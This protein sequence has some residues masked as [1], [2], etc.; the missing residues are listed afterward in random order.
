MA[1]ERDEEATEAQ[2]VVEALLVC[3]AFVSQ[4]RFDA[5]LKVL[6]VA[7]DTVAENV[8]ALGLNASRPPPTN[9]NAPSYHALRPPLPPTQI[10]DIHSFWTR[11]NT[12]WLRVLASIAL[13][14]QAWDLL[15][16]RIRAWSR[17]LEWY[18][19]VNYELGFWV[20]DLC[21]A[22]QIGRMRIQI[23]MQEA[24]NSHTAAII[25]SGD[26]MAP[27]GSFQIFDQNAFGS[28]R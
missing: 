1:P 27:T 2:L 25:G 3:D 21:K 4:L 11:L 19:L 5:A 17:A 8:E 26:G 7:T 22:V 20:K 9:P 28:T 14:P 15:E 24:Q 16:E 12:L 23:M 18:G 10:Q 13:T 6:E